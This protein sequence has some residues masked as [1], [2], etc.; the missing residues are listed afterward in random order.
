[1]SLAT[2]AFSAKTGVAGSGGGGAAG[3]S[4]AIATGAVAAD[5]VAALPTSGVT[6]RSAPP[7]ARPAGRRRGRS[8]RPAAS[9]PAVN[10]VAK[11]T[12]PLPVA[13]WPSRSTTRSAICTPLAVAASL[14]LRSSLCSLSAGTPEGSI[15]S[16]ASVSRSSSVP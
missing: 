16:H 13:R 4:V 1:M 14:P 15:S 2:L 11:V 6:A 3:M 8:G 9:P 5:G 10:G 12:L 7:P